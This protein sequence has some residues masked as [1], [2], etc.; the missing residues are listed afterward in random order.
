ML[1]TPG[2]NPFSLDEAGKNF[3]IVAGTFDFRG[4]SFNVNG[5]GNQ[6]IVDNGGNFQIGGSQ[7]FGFNAGYPLFN[8]GSSATY[9]GTGNIDLKHWTYNHLILASTG[10]YRLTSTTTGERRCVALV[11]VVPCDGGHKHADRGWRLAQNKRFYLHRRQLR[12]HLRRRR[13]AYFDRRH[14]VL[15]TAFG[16]TGRHPAVPGGR[17]H[18]CH[19]HHRVPRC[20]HSIDTDWRSIFPELHRVEPNPS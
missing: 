1:Y 13:C 5:A 11:G 14:H 7:G 6:F 10:T 4:S 19:E 15:P 2:N 12:R 3:R 16:H 18:L 20:G 8:A 9:V 17:H